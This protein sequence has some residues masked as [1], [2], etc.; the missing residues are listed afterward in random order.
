[1]CPKCGDFSEA[2]GTKTDGLVTRNRVRGESLK[3]EG[4]FITPHKWD[5]NRKKVIVN[6]DYVNRFHNTDSYTEK[7]M[8]EAGIRKIQ[9]EKIEHNVEYHG[10]ETKAIK[11]KVGKHTNI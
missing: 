7:E 1:M 10:D 8:K 9:K 11:D 6:E 4:D 2:S 5:K 3:H